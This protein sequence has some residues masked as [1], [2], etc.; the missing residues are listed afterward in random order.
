MAD[1][2]EGGMKIDI[3]GRQIE[4]TPALKEFAEEKLHKLV[5]LFLLRI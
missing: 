1:L 3:T 5:A 4:V 2:L